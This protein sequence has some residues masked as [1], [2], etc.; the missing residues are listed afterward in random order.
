MGDFDRVRKLVATGTNANSLNGGGWNPLTYAAYVGHDVVVNFLLDECGADVN[1][2]CED[3]STPLIWA[4][5][6]GNESIVYFLLQVHM[7]CSIRLTD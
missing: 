7:G 6:C 4:A 5:A 3:G 1:G 2:T